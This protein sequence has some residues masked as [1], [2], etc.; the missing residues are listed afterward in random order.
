MLLRD[1]LT[2]LLLLLFRDLIGLMLSSFLEDLL[3]EVF[4]GLQLRLP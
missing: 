1:D 2:G 3:D 4:S